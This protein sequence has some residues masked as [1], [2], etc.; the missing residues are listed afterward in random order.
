MAIKLPEFIPKAS[1]L[2]PRDSFAIDLGTSSIKIAYLKAS[3]NRYTLE[4]W[5]IIPV[6]EGGSDLSPQDKK[7]ITVT[8]LAEYLAK[9][10]FPIKNVVSSIS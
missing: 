6:N 8:R 9:E 5:G 4:K 7:N 10:K 3:G 2:K 1:F